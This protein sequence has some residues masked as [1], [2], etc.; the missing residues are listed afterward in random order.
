MKKLILLAALIIMAATTYGQ[1]FKKGNY[2][3]I[4]VFTVTLAPNVTLEQFF[5]F[6]K[7]KVLPEWEKNMPGMKNYLAKGT[8]G[9]CAN[10]YG[11]VRTYK[12]KAVLD[13]FYNEDSSMTEITKAITTKMQPLLDELGKLGTPTTKWTRWEIQ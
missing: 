12:S 8:L 6:A 4:H 1:T 5:D 3:I 11:M 7:N 10:C 9:E 13:K 2:I